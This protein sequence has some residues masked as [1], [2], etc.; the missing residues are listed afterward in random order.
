[1]HQDCKLL[2]VSDDTAGADS[3]AGDSRAGDRPDRD[4]P[5]TEPLP[6]RPHARPLAA[7]LV[8]GR[9]PFGFVEL[10]WAPT[11]VVIREGRSVRR[12]CLPQVGPPS[13]RPTPMAGRFL[14]RKRLG[15]L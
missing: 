3:R 10:A 8:A 13:R 6:Q 9:P 2:K 14:A 12:T 5:P 1:M 11:R 7:P 4:Q 15:L